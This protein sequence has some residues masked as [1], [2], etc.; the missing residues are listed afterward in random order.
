MAG[1][2]PS[3][4]RTY[5]PATHLEAVCSGRFANYTNGLPCFRGPSGQ[6]F[7]SI[8]HNCPHYCRTSH[9][10]TQTQSAPDRSLS[11]AARDQA[12]ARKAQARPCPNRLLFVRAMFG[13]LRLSPIEMRVHI[14]LG[15]N[16]NGRSG[17]CMC[18]GLRPCPRRAL[19]GLRFFHAFQRQPPP[20]FL[21]AT[22]QEL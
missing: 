13:P 22:Y 9:E 17:A 12:L 14:P 8:V 6:L 10:Q 18:V 2:L 1:K 5:H 21:A 15:P 4:P 20:R 16:L 19:R 7:H 11:T 3:A